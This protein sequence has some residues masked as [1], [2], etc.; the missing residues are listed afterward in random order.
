MC[1]DIES[2]GYSK[3]ENDD[4]LITDCQ[5]RFFGD[6][7]LTKQ[8]IA[9]FGALFKNMDGLQDR[10]VDYWDHVSA[11]LADNPYVLGYDPLNE[12]F[13]GDPIKEPKLFVPGHMD[14]KY[15]T[16]MYSRVFEKY[17]AN[18]ATKQ[19]WFEPVTF[20]DMAPWLPSWFPIWK[21]GHVF[22][23]GFETPPGGQIGSTKHVLNDHT[24]CYYSPFD[25]TRCYEWHEKKLK[26][27]DKDARRLGIPLFIT[28]F[29][30]CVEENECQAEI[31]A[32]TGISDAYL[33]S[34]AYW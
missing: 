12:P 11:R 5:S 4:P 24:Y 8:S 32:V 2:F 13:P 3:D 15:L 27:R 18:D 1:Q 25:A 22:D 23:V 10:F 20:P 9:A 26:K 28:E 19:M 31:S 30:A 6:Y 16:P 34:W 33:T 7:Y 21:D 29:G 17:Q 14:K